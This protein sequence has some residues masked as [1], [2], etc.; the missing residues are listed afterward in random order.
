MVEAKIVNGVY[1]MP[2]MKA[3]S[4]QLYLKRLLQSDKE[5]F[6]QVMDHFRNLILQ[7]SEIVKAD[8]GDGEGAV[9]RRVYLDLVPLNSFVVD[10]EFVFYDQ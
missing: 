8:R 6:L 2:Y 9:L 3:E 4:G 5:S 10:G 1:Q 7:S